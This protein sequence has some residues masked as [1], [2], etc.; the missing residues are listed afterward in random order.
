M[1]MKDSHIVHQCLS[2]DTEEF[3]LLVDKY[4][5]RIFALVYAKVGQF[6]DAEDLT[7]D[8]FL[9]AYKNLSTLR[10]WDNF[11]P[12]LYSI[13]SNQCKNFHRA[14]KR[15]VVT[16]HLA[17]Q[18]DNHRMDMHAHSEKLR[19]ERVHD[20]LASLPEM[21][22]QVLVLRY[23]A[24]MKSKEIAETLRVSP[25][26]INQRLMRARAKLKAV[27]NEEMI[28]MMHTTIAERRLQPGFTA[29]VVELI[30]DAKIQTAPQ[31]TALPLGLSAAGGVI[32][33]LLSL[34]IPHSP[35][36]PLGEWL[37]SYLPLKTQMVEDGEL[38][39][40]AEATRIAILG[41]EGD[42][43]DFGRRPIPPK[44]PAA[45]GYQ[46]HQTWGLPENAIAR[47]EKGGISSGG[48]SIAFSPD[49]ERL[50]VSTNIGVWVYDVKTTL[51][52]ALFAGGP[53]PFKGDVVFSPDGTLL[54]VDDAG[55][56]NLWEVS[57]GNKL[58]SFRGYASSSVVFSP[59][60]TKL[61]SG[62]VDTTVR[63][64][65]ISKG[66]NITSFTGHTKQVISV[67][68][69]PD[70][71]KLASGSVDTT[72][73]L[74]EISAGKNA[75]LLTGH[76]DDVVSLVFSPDGTKLASGSRD[77]TIK[78]W[79]VAT[80]KNIATRAD[81]VGW[82]SSVAFS[83]DGKKLA[84]GA[85]N[86]TV[87]LW[88]AD[89]LHPITM[90]QVPRG[91]HSKAVAFSPDGALLAHT[92]GDLGEV[93]LWNISAG[94][95]V[96]TITGHHTGVFSLAFSPD[97]TTLATKVS[98]GEVK[99]WDVATG[100]YLGTPKRNAGW[101][102]SYAYSEVNSILAMIGTTEVYLRDISTGQHI[103]ALVGRHTE[104]ITSVA[105]SP[106]GTR[107]ASG[108][109]DNSV[110][111]WDVSTETCI[112]TLEHLGTVYFVAF[113]PDGLTLASASEDKTV[114]LWDVS[115]ESNFAILEHKDSVNSV[116]FS[117]DGMTLASG[118]G[119]GYGT[120]KLWKISTRK[121]IATLMGHTG[122][123]SSIAFSPDGTKLASASGMGEV[124]LWNLE[125]VDD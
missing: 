108:S 101:T 23:M 107:L 105:F 88:K 74:W 25:N 93:A 4:K 96:G 75:A 98:Y 29:C 40:D 76:T 111:L 61:A 53:W 14:Q 47:F 55:H 68:F 62:M 110:K 1:H 73:K 99:L 51:E 94:K 118:S 122:S 28:Q 31:K 79:E 58:A 18:D 48:R 82:V 70:G 115:T 27:F 50:A 102:H 56:I 66:K 36:Y 13:A 116:A 19:N 91:G 57:T 6:Q 84:S 104:Q 65:E 86:G 38:P 12:W 113:S 2:G 52:L 42:D 21:H 87:R 100:R 32:L 89:T 16:A 125:T 78:L 26:T 119:F 5:D 15:Q 109:G 20:A 63:L 69:S 72:I 95:V 97:G 80:G 54:A 43:E 35:L 106:D 10:R 92:R 64:W 85:L 39:V 44:M 30:S 33:L 41:A 37:G 45:I 60:G 103:G 59:D 123:V 83:P 9:E 11:Y 67:A 7:Q 22:R 117:P 46:D 71:T 8:V 81:H 90:I 77:N 120:I 24:G 17:R 34:T 49:G 124:L 114:K 121:N 112:A 3:A